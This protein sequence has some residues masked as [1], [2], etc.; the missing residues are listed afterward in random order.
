MVVEMVVV[1]DLVAVTVA[2]VVTVTVV[3]VTTERIDN[4]GYRKDCTHNHRLEH[5][6]N[7]RHYDHNICM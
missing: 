4:S 5:Y 2:V 1:A 7:S 6:R 3:A